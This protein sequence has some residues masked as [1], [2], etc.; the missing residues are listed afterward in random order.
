ME[1]MKGVIKRSLISNPGG[2]KFIDTYDIEINTL[3]R[4]L[5]KIEFLTA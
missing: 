4:L 3:K 2:Q 1:H 5:N